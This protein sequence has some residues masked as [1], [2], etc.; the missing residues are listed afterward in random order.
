[1]LHN[2]WSLHQSIKR[3]CFD[4]LA[5]HI[6]TILALSTGNIYSSFGCMSRI[7]SHVSAFSLSSATQWFSWLGRSLTHLHY[8]WVITRCLAGQRFNDPSLYLRY[9]E[10]PSRDEGCAPPPPPR[11]QE[12]KQMLQNSNYTWRIFQHFWFMQL[13]GIDW[14]EFII[15]SAWYRL[16]KMAMDIGWAVGGSSSRSLRQAQGFWRKC[17]ENKN[18]P[19]TFFF[20]FTSNPGIQDGLLKINMGGDVY[21]VWSWQA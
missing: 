9:I 15:P 14:A 7:R 17:L 2:L 19:K 18:R 21:E 6:N 3:K 1:M 12:V 13:G 8:T 20:Y 10:T 4:T 16:Y 5:A 11:A